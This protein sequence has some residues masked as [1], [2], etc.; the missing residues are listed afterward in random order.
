M[1]RMTAQ[2]KKWQAESDAHALTR[3]AEIT[4]DPARLKAAQAILEE[5][6]AATAVA[7]QTATASATMNAMIRGQTKNQKE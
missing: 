4:A 7:L 1:A 5:Q 2:E 6:A 3:H